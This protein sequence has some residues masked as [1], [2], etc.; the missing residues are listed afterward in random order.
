[1]RRAELLNLLFLLLLLL[2]FFPDFQRVAGEILRH[3]FFS[4]FLA[5]ALGVTGGFFSSYVIESVKL[6]RSVMGALKGLRG[7]IL[8]NIGAIKLLIDG[9]ENIPS[10][11]NPS[12]Y[13]DK[14]AITQM[15]DAEKF[16]AAHARET[17]TDKSY[18]EILNTLIELEN[19]GLFDAMVNSYL[20]LN[21]LRSALLMLTIDHPIKPSARNL[22][23]TRLEAEK[24]FVEESQALKK[25]LSDWEDFDRKVLDEIGSLRK[26][27]I[28]RLF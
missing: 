10:L 26:K 6:K 20:S 4:E 1:M 7:E 23:A 19:V 5:V 21:K 13:T 9:I 11:T 15:I 12:A 27:I 3:R 8:G 22:K 28:Y 2:I 25:L 24:S 16:L 18:V 14:Q 17:L